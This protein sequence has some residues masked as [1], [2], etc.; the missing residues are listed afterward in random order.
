M[1]VDAANRVVNIL[2]LVLLLGVFLLSLSAGSSDIPVW[3]GLRDYLL[4][5]QPLSA[6][7]LIVGE[8]RLPRSLLALG[9][10]A[11]L[12]LAGAALQGLLRNPLVEPGL[13]GASS[14]AALGA[15]GVFYYGLFASLGS[16]AMPAAGL[17]GAGLTL[18]L[19]LLLAGSHARPGVLIMAGLAVST[20]TGALL[21]TVLNFAPNPYAMQE[22]VFW[23]LGSVSLR[24]MDQVAVL[25]PLL[26]LG[27]LILWPQRRL[28]WGLSLGEATAAS[29]GLNVNRGA[30]W[31]VLGSALLVGAAVSVAGSVGFVGLL[32]PHLARPWVG[33]RPDRLLLP[34][35]LLGAIL[36]SLADLLLRLSP[37]G[38]ELKLGV[39]TALVGAPF[40][41][42]LV[43]RERQR[44]L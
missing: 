8:I 28:L 37:P 41:I 35:L 21:A 24:G 14:G 13:I 29:M 20:L 2:L 31:V 26:L 6:P 42:Y 5:Q 36:V 39:L 27:V 1:A 11:A 30:R 25:F 22:L 32:A 17:I 18:W 33:S 43:W 44:W 7:G 15:A 19:L 12:G 9:V 10:G 34:S 4:Q 23:M 3:Q 16:L 38:R 40:F